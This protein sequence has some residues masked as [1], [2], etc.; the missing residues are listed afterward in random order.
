MHIRIPSYPSVYKFQF[1]VV[2]SLYSSSPP[3]YIKIPILYR[4]KLVFQFYIS[5][6][7]NFI[8][9]PVQ[10]DIRILHQLFFI[11]ILHLFNLYSSAPSIETDFPILGQ[12]TLKLQL[13]ISAFFYSK[14]SKG[15]YFNSSFGSVGIYIQ[16][17][18]QLYLY[19]CWPSV[20]FWMPIVDRFIFKFE[21]VR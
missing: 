12:F 8:C 3:D 14:F 13:C 21:I 7:L 6:Y 19:S 11:P 5:L 2:F 9:R 4:L 17:L 10:I 20:Y 18:R 16:V 1:S 15:L